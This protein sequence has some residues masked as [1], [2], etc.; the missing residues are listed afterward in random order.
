[1]D[2]EELVTQRKLV[3]ARIREYRKKRNLTQMELYRTCGI[4]TGNL[5]YIEQGK[6]FPSVPAVAALARC[7]QCS[8][9][10]LI[11]G[12]EPERET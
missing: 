10:E 7:F 6:I 12:K 1:M 9:D 5:S 4:S 2:R 11:F 8:T 3:G